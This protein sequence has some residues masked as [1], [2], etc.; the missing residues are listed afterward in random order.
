MFIHARACVRV[1]VHA[2]H[3]RARP[4]E[5]YTAACPGLL[6]SIRDIPH[7]SHTCKKRIGGGGAL[8]GCPPA[9]TPMPMQRHLWARG[10]SEP[11]TGQENPPLFAPW[12]AP[13][14]GNARFPA[15]PPSPFLRRARVTLF[16]FGV[17]PLGEMARDERGR[18]ACCSRW[19]GDPGRSRRCTCV[20]ECVW[21]DRRVQPSSTLF[22]NGRF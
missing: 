6:H 19:S 7:S 21:A 2:L 10:T 17:S 14:S 8:L 16:R 9:T 3:T 11:F 12:E 13:C 20:C 1:C 18:E 22:L 4:S 5:H 15:F